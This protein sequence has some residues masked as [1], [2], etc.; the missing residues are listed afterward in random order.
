MSQ[1]L[2]PEQN[3]FKDTL[4][5]F[6]ADNFPLEKARERMGAEAARSALEELG[7]TGYLASDDEEAGGVRELACLALE[8][9]YSLAPGHLARN[10]LFGP[11]LLSRLLNSDADLKRIGEKLANDKAHSCFG[12]KRDGFDANKCFDLVEAADSSQ[13]LVGLDSR[14]LAL[15]VFG[16]KEESALS[17]SEQQCLDLCVRS[18]KVDVGTLSSKEVENPKVSSRA[19]HILALLTACEIAGCAERA[20][21]MTREYVAQRKQFGVPVGG[22]QAVQHKLVD[23]YVR[24][25]AMRA[26]SFFAATAAD[27]VMD[28]DADPSSSELSVEEKQFYLSSRAALDQARRYGPAIIEG[29]IQLHGGIGFTWEHDLHLFLRRVRSLVAQY[30]GLFDGAENSVALADLI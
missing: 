10:L 17:H 26:L 30:G 11:F 6:F 15:S 25:E 5:R 9:G 27:E 14:T 29:A 22:F 20:I 23:L 18:Y 1:F 2:N 24:N 19:V 12:V 8:L 28:E 21:N 13:V 4:R 7:L 16:Y 3:E